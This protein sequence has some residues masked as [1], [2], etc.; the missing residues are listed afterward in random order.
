MRVA[1]AIAPPLMAILRPQ[2]LE[3]FAREGEQHAVGGSHGAGSGFVRRA[4][5][6]AAKRLARSER[7]Q[8]LFVSVQ[9]ARNSQ[10]P[11]RMK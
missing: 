5:L 2:Q 11:L 4:S 3:V 6:P 8:N 7:F 10:L 9:R 1:I